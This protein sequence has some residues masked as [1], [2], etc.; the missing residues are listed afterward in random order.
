MS[1]SR[2]SRRSRAS[3][4]VTWSAFA[5]MAIVMCVGVVVW[6]VATAEPFTPDVVLFPAAYLAFGGVGAL[7]LSR[8]PANL[9]GRLAMITGAAGAIFGMCDSL[10]RVTDPVPGREWLAWIATWGFPLSLAAP[11]LLIVLF[12]SGRLPSRRWRI[13]AL[14]ILAGAAA[15]TVGNALTPTL[16]DHPGVRNPVG[17]AWFAGSVLDGGGVGWLPLLGGA[18]A[19]AIGLI[20]RLRSAGG[21]EREQ[22]KWITFAAALHGSSW[23]VLALDLLGV[24]GEAA[25]YAMFATLMLIPL[26]TG[27]AVLRYRLYEIDVVIRRTVLYTAVVVVLG[28]IYVALVLTLQAVL[29]PITGGDVL[30]VA[31]STL[32]TAA[33]FGP[34]RRRVRELVDRRFNRSAYDAQRMVDA[35]ADRLRDA[36]DLDFVKQTLVTVAVEAVRPHV[37]GVWMRADR[38]GSRQRSG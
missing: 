18:V 16:V 27:I 26:A 20:P 15:V 21:I 32:A 30:P 23:I 10:A 37:A 13:V 9:V 12:P 36:G 11:L 38:D 4:I 2:R 28:A 25:A 19:A 24:A 8:Q 35:L 5:V 34:V 29:A 1:L 7:I 17:V 14:A 3:V 6:A 22:F 31:I 33:S